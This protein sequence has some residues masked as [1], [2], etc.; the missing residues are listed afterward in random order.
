MLLYRKTIFVV[1]LSNLIVLGSLIIKKN[2]VYSRVSFNKNR[3]WIY[4]KV[5][6]LLSLPN[7]FKS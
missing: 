1:L 4:K 2:I 3:P 6:I 7:T 5:R